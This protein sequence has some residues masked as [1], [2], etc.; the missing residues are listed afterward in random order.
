[1]LDSVTEPPADG[2]DISPH[3][4]RCPVCDASPGVL[5]AMRHPAMRAWTDELLSAEHGCWTVVQPTPD[6]LLVDAI[7]RTLP[8]LVVVDSSDFPSCCRDALNSLPPER[9]IVVG[10]EPS[11][12]YQSFAIENGAG[13]W[14]SRDS[15]ADGLS[16]SMRGALGCSHEP[17][18]SSPDRGATSMNQQ[19]REELTTEEHRERVERLQ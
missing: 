16:R 6:E 13:G 10:P 1:M 4:G 14:V 15:V 18:P 8:D 9:V 12:A 3:E 2:S 5:V 19:T 7:S 17:C 11:S